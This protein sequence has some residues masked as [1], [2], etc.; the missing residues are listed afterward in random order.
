MGKTPAANPEGSFGLVKL[1]SWGTLTLILLTSLALSIFLANYARQFLLAK[2][3]EFA[4]LL[5][6]NLN[7]QIYR[8][9]TLPAFLKY[10]EVDLSNPEQ[11]KLLDTVVQST[12]EG[13]GVTDVHIYDHNRVMSYSSDKSLVGNKGLA[14]ETVDQ[15][16]EQGKTNFA[17]IYELGA[18]GGFFTRDLAPQSVVMR[19]TYALRAEIA[20]EAGKPS[21]PIMGALEFSQDITSDYQKLI[22]FQRIIILTALGSAAIEFLLLLMIIHRAD[23]GNAQ[24]LRERENFE[25]ELMQNEKLASIGRVVAGIA[26]EIRNPLGI[27]RSSSELLVTRLKDKDPLTAQILT[28]INEESVRLS[29]TVGDFLDYARPRTPKRDP[30]DLAQVLD[31]VTAFLEYKCREQGVELVRQY[32]PGLN[33]LGDK[34]LLYRA[35]YNVVVNSLEAMAGEPNADEEG[36]GPTGQIVVQGQTQNG[37]VRLSILDTGPGFS[38][39]AK[40]SLLDPFFTTKDHGTGLG[41]AI[42][43]N[44]VQSHGA[45]LV[46]SENENGGA[47]VDMT[48][49]RA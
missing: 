31:S 47:R 27:I 11:Y 1:V 49:A 36:H 26:H 6:E 15:A 37:Q 33:V 34:D 35:F 5:A 43:A 8:R 4:V 18:F 14:G 9:F 39:E 28:A 20:L 29:K 41:L 7:H 22:N 13:L 25:R 23:R 21:G 3:H 46:L 45:E 16:L 24:R 40:E 38:P 32:E 10:E 44:I 48:F 12:L 17:L 30:V 19:T 2:Q 42:V